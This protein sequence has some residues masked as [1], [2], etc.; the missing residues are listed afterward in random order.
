MPMHAKTDCRLLLGDRPCV[1][2][3][4]CQGCEHYVKRGEHIVIIKLAAAGDVLRTT[5][6]LPP[7]KRAHPDSFITWVTDPAALPLIELNPYLDRA[8]PFG[9]DAWLTL[10]AQSIDLLICLDKEERACA[11]AST[12]SASAKSGFALSTAG[13]VEPLNEGA[14]YDYE[15]GLSNEM[16]FH[17]NTMT[18]PAIFCRTA[19]LEYQGEPYLLALPEAAIEHARRFLGSLSL[20]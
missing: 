15:L 5:S 10:S 13:A 9:F 2:G 17:E 4:E 11:L 12:L 14:R 18:Y 19:G 8:V 7:L 6:I 20:S 1:W 16:K 3:G